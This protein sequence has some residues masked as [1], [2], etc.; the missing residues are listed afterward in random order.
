M[1]ARRLHTGF[2]LIEL[3]VVIAIVGIMATMAMPSYQDRIARTQI[4]EALQL[5]T[6]AQDEVQVYYRTHKRLPADNAA[7][8]L[9]PP[10]KIVGN[11]VAGLQVV[12]GA[13]HLKFGNNA[14]RRLAGKT[15]TL[16]PAIVKDHP[17]VP[18]A[19]VCGLANVPGAMQAMGE[20]RTDLPPQFL[21]VDCRPGPAPAAAS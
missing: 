21:P 8:G 18:V 17:R 12:E 5:A 2:T 11:Y 13:A 6:L 15:L 10:D 7:A 19:W 14:N 3:M 20:N 9:P 4:K 16:R 1:T